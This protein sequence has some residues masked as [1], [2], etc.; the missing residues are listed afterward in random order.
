MVMLVADLAAAFICAVLSW[1]YGLPFLHTA[2]G[3]GD[4]LVL[5]IGVGTVVGAALAL[6]LAAWAPGPQPVT[7]AAAAGQPGPPDPAGAPR[8]RLSLAAQRLGDRAS[9]PGQ[10]AAALALAA[11]ADEWPDG[12]QDCI[13][14]LCQYLRLPYDPAAARSAESQ[15]RLSIV[16]AL[17]SHLDGTAGPGWPGCR[18][19]FSGAT[20]DRGSLGGARFAGGTVR[21]TGCRFTGEGLSLRQAVFTECVL[22]CARIAIDGGSTLDFTGAGLDRS[23]T[24]FTGIEL[25]AGLLSF[26]QTRWHA[27]VHDFSDLHLDGGEIRFDKAYFTA[28]RAL[29]DPDVW[30]LLDFANGVLEAGT[31]T[32]RE[33]RFEYLP[34]PPPDPGRKRRPGTGEDDQAIDEDALMWPAEL[35]TLRKARLAGAVVDFSKAEFIKGEVRMFENAAGGTVLF[36]GAQFS[37]GEVSFRCSQLD[38][39]LLDFSRA[40]FWQD[41]QS[42]RGDGFFPQRWMT[43]IAEAKRGDGEEHLHFMELPYPRAAVDF[44]DAV[45]DKTKAEFECI[46]AAGGIID[47]KGAAFDRAELCFVHASFEGTV[48]VL[49]KT[50]YRTRSGLLRL[51]RSSR[52][53]ILTDHHHMTHN[54][55]KVALAGWT[56]PEHGGDGEDV[57]DLRDVSWCYGINSMD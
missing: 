30:S 25:A 14:V 48:I 45:L 57:S 20:F 55:L 26:Q 39:C 8:E 27:G 7:R 56:G 3:S 43:P 29:S 6:P 40:V 12:R 22:D 28:S 1:R 41:A 53:V 2:A 33:A 23:H 34:E 52:P 50:G 54:R 11:L 35:L 24:R 42:V 37:G 13:D 4:R 16:D 15:V 36:R 17:R 10:M 47:F 9:P 51:S 44:S 21:F 31:L 46:T 5:A 32:L 49:W 19:D 18:F 38:D